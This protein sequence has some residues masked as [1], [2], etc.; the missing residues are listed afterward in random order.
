[1]I[2]ES[3][4]EASILRL[5]LLMMSR[6]SK[7]SSMVLFE[8]RFPYKYG[9]GAASLVRYMKCGGPKLACVGEKPEG[10]ILL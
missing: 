2:S 5:V 9:P 4:Q 7:V 8:K 1:M 10:S 3:T 6:T